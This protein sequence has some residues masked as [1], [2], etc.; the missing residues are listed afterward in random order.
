MLSFDQLQQRV[1]ARFSDSQKVEDNVIRFVRKSNNHPFAVCYLALSQDLPSDEEELSKYQD[2]V[3]GGLYF[4]GAKSLQWS[5]YLYFIT[6]S[7]RLATAKVQRAKEWIENNRSYARKFV[8][9]DQEIDEILVPPVAAPE[10]ESTRPNVISIWTQELQAHGLDKAIFSEDSMPSRLSAIEATDVPV[11]RPSSPSATRVS[12]RPAFLSSLQLI[13][14]RSYPLNRDFEFGTMNLLFGPNATGKTSLLEA[15]ELLYC[16]RNKRNEDKPAP[17]ELFATYADGK[18]ERAVTNRAL[19]IFRDRN[20][21]WYGQ[22]EVLTNNLYQSFSKFNFLDTDA[23]VRIAESTEDLDQDLSKLLIGPEASKIWDNIGRVYEALETRL[24]DQKR[25]KKQLDD[26]LAELIKRLTSIAGLKYESDSI[27]ASLKKMLR[28]LRW[29]ADSEKIDERV[30]GHIVSSLAE[31]IAVAE[32]ATSLNWIKSPASRSSLVKFASDATVS[33]QTATASLEELEATIKKQRQIEENIKRQDEVEALLNQLRLFVEARLPDRIQERTQCEKNISTY[34]SLLAGFDSTALNEPEIAADGKSK[35]G[36]RERHLEIRNAKAAAQATLQRTRSEYSRFAKLREKSVALAQELRSIASQIIEKSEDTDECPL[37][38]T[39]FPKG[40]L[41][42]HMN[43][44]VDDHLEQI[45][46]A[47]INRQREQQDALTKI[48]ANETFYAW[49]VSFCERASTTNN[50]SVARAIALLGGAQ[51]TLST[52]AQRKS[53][54]DREMSA[55]AQRGLTERRLLEIRSRLSALKKSVSLTIEAV[56]DALE[57]ARTESAALTKSL[58]GEVK[59]RRDRSAALQGLLAAKDQEFDTLKSALARFKECIATTVKIGEELE[60]FVAEFPWPARNSLA[61]LVVSA[62]SVS[63]LAAS[64]RKSLSQEKQDRKAYAGLE[65]RR[66][67]LESQSKEY[68]AR[69]KRLQLAYDTLSKLR[70]DHSLQDEMNAALLQ[71]RKAIETIFS[72]IHAPVEFSGLSDKFPLLRRKSDEED[73]KLTEISTGQRAAYALSI[74]LA[75]NSQLTNAPPV[76]LIDDP[77]AHV[78]DLNALSF[79]DYLREVALLGTR[80]IFFATAND[81]LATLIERKFDFL[82]NGF[83][84]FALNRGA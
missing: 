80:Q 45:G 28:R 35:T 59:A 11:S 27:E 77:I 66:K 38:H 41:A 29:P 18:T 83:K 22:P 76:V 82:G 42:E 68:Q 24:R 47:L 36:L 1:S 10:G 70:K 3:V 74:F 81:K 55:L 26:E 13:K 48:T 51:N 19:R 33:V 16:G 46:Q 62:S 7:Q 20:L 34:T 49:L 50:P 79:L 14:Y 17:Y 9:S 73:A 53:V 56:D 40:K 12:R 21:A 71:N 4:E 64:L 67:L 72:Q 61:D 58:Q 84:K 2:R 31:L 39:S 54:L 60:E 65:K 75:Q 69:L 43:R 63:A 30:A 5:N 52:S 57:S 44:G 32:Q 23:A 25:L 78:D 37:C 15:I 6:S 8:I